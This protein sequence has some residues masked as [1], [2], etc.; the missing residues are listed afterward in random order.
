MKEYDIQKFEDKLYASEQSSI[1]YTQNKLK[2]ID[3]FKDRFDESI[4]LSLC[5]PE[6]RVTKSAGFNSINK[7]SFKI[8]YL[9]ESA[10]HINTMYKDGFKELNEHI[11]SNAAYRDH[12]FNIVKPIL[13]ARTGN[14]YIMDGKDILWII[15]E[16]E[17]LWTYITRKSGIKSSDFGVYFFPIFGQIIFLC[18]LF[19]IIKYFLTQGKHYDNS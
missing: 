18:V 19:Y 11:V 17:S 13:K 6:S 15:P 10:N 16:T 8:Q 3:N 5:L 9:I 2:E 4:Y 12:V 1:E 7:E 14:D